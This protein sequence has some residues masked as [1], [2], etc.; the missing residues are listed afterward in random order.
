MGL[1][2]PLYLKIKSKK[3]SKT[4]LVIVPGNHVK[5]DCVFTI[6]NSETG[7]GLASHLCSNSS[8]A[9]SDLYN[10]RPERIKEWKEKF[11]DVEV[12]FINETN[13]N[14]DDLLKKNKEFHENLEKE[15]I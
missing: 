3:M 1:N 11:G 2:C 9:K 15:E 7:E 6:L 12:K 10:G 13:I 14:E 5:S 8:Y 4:L